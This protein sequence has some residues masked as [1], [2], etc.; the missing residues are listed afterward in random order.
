MPL[1]PIDDETGLRALDARCASR[2]SAYSRRAVALLS[3]LSPK[4]K[5]DYLFSAA[6]WDLPHVVR[7][8]VEAGA[9]VHAVDVDGASP[10]LAAA[11]D[12]SANAVKALLECGADHAF[13]MRDSL[14][15]ALSCAA[16]E[17]SIACVQLLLAAGADAR[18][19]DFLRN[20][21]LCEAMLSKNM[22]CV[23]ALLALSDLSIVAR[24]GMNAL[25]SSVA[26]LSLECLELLLPLVSD[27]DVRTQPGLDPSS[28]FHQTALH[29]ACHLGE[30]EMAKALLRRGADR[31]ARDSVM[32]T[33]LMWAAQHGHLSCCVLLVGQPGRPKMTPAEVSAPGKNGYTALHIAADFGHEKVCGVLIEAGARLDAVDSDGDTP[34][35]LAQQLPSSPAKTALLALLSGAGS[36]R[37]PG[38]GCDHC[39]KTAEQASVN[40]L[41]GCTQCLAVRYCNAACQTAAW[42]GHKVACKARKAER[43][44]KSLPL[45]IK[46]QSP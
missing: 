26:C 9:S 22:E 30:P 10:L 23:K 36:A 14:Y 18:S 7:C 20:T 21:P 38:T 19:T 24:D 28:V 17:G 12:G 6:V 3:S 13:V 8:A 40:S 29:L 32:W 41:K 33:P 37:L 42:P 43:E 1:P 31:M 16:R 2:L 4:R 39:G 45:V 11:S 15:T 5:E 25:H 46:P 34:L 44:V 27:V 35:M